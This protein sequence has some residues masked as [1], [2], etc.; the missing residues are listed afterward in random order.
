MDKD[1]FRYHITELKDE[2]FEVANMPSGKYDK[3]AVRYDKLI[4]NVLYNKIMWG[5]TPKD[6]S[7]FCQKV[8]NRHVDGI[9]ADIGCGTLSFTSKVYANKQNQY[10]FLCDLSIEMLK[11]GKKRV[12]FI[13]KDLSRL[14]FLRADALDMPFINNSIQAVLS[15]GFLH[16]IDNPSKLID[17]FNRILDTEGK[18][19]LTSL[20]TDRKLSDKYLNF[21]H[22]K[23][24]VAKPL[25]SFEII[26][27]IED[28]GFRIEESSIKG[29]MIYISAF[30]KI[31][32]Y[33]KA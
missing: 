25:S 32:N 15:F 12:E 21:L 22:R 20:C 13:S 2:I 23:G 7:N 33:N 3:Q 10:L 18:L 24:H 31:R 19:Y 8:I 6:Y 1:L 28:N 26:K 29:G 16:V 17:E 11:I 14:T 27:I 9:I 4:S 5:N 30:K